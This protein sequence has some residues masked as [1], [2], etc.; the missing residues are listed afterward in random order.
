[1][2]VLSRVSVPVAV[3]VESNILINRQLAERLRSPRRAIESGTYPYVRLRIDRPP[4]VA[5]QWSPASYSDVGEDA[6]HA[7]RIPLPAFR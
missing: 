2:L 6:D 5:H 1:M 7:V 3:R 4:R